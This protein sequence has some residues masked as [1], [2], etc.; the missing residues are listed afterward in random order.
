MEGPARDLQRPGCFPG[1]WVLNGTTS[2]SMATSWWRGT[3]DGDLLSF[4][5]TTG[6]LRID[7]S[8]P[9]TAGD[10]AGGRPPGK[11]I[12]PP[13]CRQGGRGSAGLNDSLP[14]RC[15]STD[16]HPPV[17]EL[18]RSPASGAS[19]STNRYEDEP[20]GDRDRSHELRDW[21][22]R[23]GFDPA[24]MAKPGR[25]GAQAFNPP[26]RTM[27][28]WRT[29]CAPTA[30]PIA[31]SQP[32]SGELTSYSPSPWGRGSGWGLAVG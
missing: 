11:V 6:P 4:Q 3:R 18:E 17:Y 28:I 19:T 24:A 8:P 31:R 12:P 5:T 26:S 15:E 16:P 23:L 13:C 22:R 29:A 32:T 30:A 2:R 10:R 27:K 20:A 1:L 14:R 7:R 9:L 25:G 21:L